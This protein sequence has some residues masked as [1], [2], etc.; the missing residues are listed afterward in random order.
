MSNIY[1]KVRLI[2][3]PAERKRCAERLVKM[4][5][6]LAPLRAKRKDSSILLATWNIRDLGAKKFNPDGRMKESLHYLAEVASCFDLIALQE[7]N[8]EIKD[9]EALV[10]MLGGSWDYILTDMTEGTPG[11]GE[12]MAYLYNRDR[13]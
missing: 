3:D 12:R 6:T 4:R 7:V 5:A 13:V 9:F 11:N 2:D 8:E 1:T 10:A